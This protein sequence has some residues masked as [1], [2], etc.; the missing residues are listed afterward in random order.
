MYAPIIFNIFEFLSQETI[1]VLLLVIQFNCILETF[2]EN[3]R[4]TEK[5]NHFVDDQQPLH[6]T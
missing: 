2:F 6:S 5:P 1:S 4:K 3:V